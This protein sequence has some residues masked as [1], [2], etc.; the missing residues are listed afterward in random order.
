MLHERAQTRLFNRNIINDTDSD[1][2][3]DKIGWYFGNSDAKLHA[4]KSKD[5]NAWGL[6]DM[7]GNV[8]ESST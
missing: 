5:P 7:N 1:P 6:Y 2:N 8:L 4:V 3:L